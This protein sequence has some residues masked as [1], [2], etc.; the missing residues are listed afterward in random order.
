MELLAPA[1]ETLCTPRLVLRP[2]SLDDT[3][4]VVRICAPKEVAMNTLSVAHP[5]TLTDAEAFLGRITESMEKRETYC[6]AITIPTPSWEPG[7]HIGTI[8]L[9]CNWEHRHAEVGYTIGRPDWGK[10]Y[11]T[12]SLRAVIAFAFA[13][14]PLVRLHAGYY[15]RNPASGRVLEKC[16]FVQEGTRPR[17]YQRFGDWIDLALMRLFREDWE[18]TQ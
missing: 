15:T 5:Y 13:R 17:M 9:H 1:I 11:A 8:G 6:W 4:S 10:G 3:V 12:E 2:L 7:K 16:G 14:T 18:S